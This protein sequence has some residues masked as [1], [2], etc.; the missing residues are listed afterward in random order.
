[1]KGRSHQWPPSP[2]PRKHT[3][4]KPPEAR[5]VC[6]CMRACALRSRWRADM[7]FFTQINRNH[8]YFS[9]LSPQALRFRCQARLLPYVVLV[10]PGYIPRHSVGE[11][12]PSL[13][14]VLFFGDRQGGEETLGLY[15]SK[16][17]MHSASWHESYVLT[18]VNREEARFRGRPPGGQH[19]YR[20]QARPHR[21]HPRRQPQV[22][23]PAPRLG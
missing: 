13:G 19:P 11:V 1:M 17:R 5:L 16:A 7:E 15:R 23:C 22:P 4:S 3:A 14:A 2:S 6:C 12:I 21:P 8:G 20:C 18:S 10:K 9:R